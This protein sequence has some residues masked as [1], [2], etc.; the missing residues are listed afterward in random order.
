MGPDLSAA[1]GVPGNIFPLSAAQQGVWY[2]EHL[3]DEFPINVAQYVEIRGEL[4]LDTFTDACLA[5]AREMGT[6]YLR[7]T[8]IDGTPYQWVDDEMVQVVE[9]LDFT[10][11][12]NDP[13]IAALEWMRADYLKPLDLT[14]DGL[15]VMAI[16]KIGVDH[17]YWYGRMHH[18]A[19]DGYAGLTLT[20]RT[21]HRY[22]AALAGREPDVFRGLPL[23]DLNEA[24]QKYRASSRFETDAR[25]WAEQTADLPVVVN[26]SGRSGGPAPYNR[27]A[28]GELPDTVAADLALVAKQLEVSPAQVLLAA[29][30]VFLTKMTGTD[31]TMVTLPVTGRTTMALKR[32][33]GMV[34]NTV[35]IVLRCGPGVSVS[36]LIART[37][38]DITGALRHQRY[39][40]EDIRR[41]AGLADPHTGS[42]GPS[43]NMMFFDTEIKFGDSIGR[44]NI[45]TSGALDDLRINLYQSGPDAP[46]SVDFHGNPNNYD[47][48]ELTG[49][50][51][52]FLLLLERFLT[53]ATTTEVASLDVLTECERAELVAR[54]D[55]ADT[56]VELLPDLLTTFTDAAALAVTAAD[57]TM[58]YGELDERSSQLARTL[59]D[60]GVGAEDVVAV[61]IP[62]SIESVLAVWAVAKTGAAFAPIDPNYPAERIAHMVS[63]SGARTGLTVGA[64]M[65]ALPT[66]I[67][68]LPIDRTDV[69]QH[70]SAPVSD[71]DRVRRVRPEHA[72]YLIYTSGS[73]GLPKGVVVTHRGLAGLADAERVEFGVV[74]DSRVAH[75]CS[76][77]FDVSILE[78][79][80]TFTAGATL[81]VVPPPV[82][83]GAELSDLLRREHVSH[84]IITPGAL[85]TVDPAGLHELEV[86]VGAGEAISPVLVQQWGT[87]RR[88]FNGYGPT[89][90]TIL[91]TTTALTPGTPVTI[92]DAV[93]GVGA[94]VL[95]RRLKPVPVGV[96]GE[97][98]LAGPQL[99]RGY[100]ARSATT[101]DRFVASPFVAG[102]RMYRTGDVVRLRQTGEL[103]YSGRNDFQL[104]IRG[105]RVELGEIDAALVEHPQVESAVTVGNANTAGAVTLVSYIVGAAIDVDRLAD[106]LAKTLPAHMVPTTIMVLAQ[107]PLT[108]VGKIDRSALP[109]PERQARTYRAPATPLEEIVAG[110]YA[111]VL[112]HDRVGRDDHFFELGGDSLSATH[113]VSRLGAALDTRISVRELFDAPTVSAIAA[114]AGTH[115]G[116][117]APPALVARERPARIPLSSAQQRMWLVNQ[118]DP[119]SAA[120]NVPG[121]VRLTGPLD[122]AA[123]ATAFADVLGRHESLRTVF[124][125]DGGLPHQVIGSVAD[126]LVDVDLSP[127]AVDAGEIDSRIGVFAGKGFDVAAAIP[128]R[129]RLLQVDPHTH[130]LVVVL[131]HI[132]SDG[133]STGPL[134]RDVI[135]AYDT[136][137]RGV[138][139][140]GSR[141]AM[142][143]ADY[144]LWQHEVLGDPDDPESVFAHQIDYWRTAL[145]GVPELLPLATD[146]PRPS[147]ASGRGATVPFTI[148]ADLNERLKQT[149]QAHNVTVFMVV[150]AALAALLAR[151]SGTSDV[152]VGTPVAGRGAAELDDMVGM[153]VNTVALR[154]GIELGE[155]FADLL[156]RV[157]EADLEAFDNADV[158]FEHVVEVCNPAR[159]SSYSPIV[160]VAL[161]YEGYTERKAAAS[162]VEF[163]L[164]DPPSSAT[165]FDLLVTLTELGAPASTATGLRA[166]LGYATDLFD[167]DTV[168]LFAHRFLRVLDAVTADATVMVG[169]VELLCP[170]ELAAL[171]PVRGRAGAEPV[172]LSRLL[173]DATADPAAAA[174]VLGGTSLTYGELDRR[175]NSLARILVERGARPEQLVAL[176]LPRSIDLVIAVWAVAKTGAAWLPI[177]ATHPVERIAHL[178]T[179]SAATLGV[180]LSEHR[181]VLGG[182]ANWVELDDGATIA[183]LAFRSD[184][185]IGAGELQATTTPDNAA[186]VIYT[187]GSTGKPKGVTVTHRGLANFAAEQRERYGVQPD[188]RVLQ[189]ASPSFDAWVLEFLLAVGAGATMVVTPPGLLGGDDLADLLTSERITHAFLTPTV[190]SSLQPAALDFPHTLVAGGEELP[191]D[192]AGEWAIGRRLH[193]GYGPTETTIMVCIS[194]PIDSAERVT[195]GGPIRGTSAVVLDSRLRP[196]PTGAIG[197]LYIAGL[198]CA[199]GY[200]GKAALT[201]SRFVADPFGG[202]G[203]Q[204]YRTGDLVRWTKDLTLEYVGRSDFQVKVRGFRIELGEIDAA[205]RTH[206]DVAFAVTVARDTPAGDSALV[207]YVSASASSTLDSAAV[208]DH[209]RSLLPAYMVPTKVVELEEIPLNPVGKLDRTA[210]PDPGF[211]S[212]L[213]FVVPRSSD[214]HIIAG[215]FADVLGV[216]RVSVLDGFFELGG[217]SLSATQVV[218]RLGVAFGRRVEVRELFAAGTVAALAER[219]ADTPVSDVAPLVHVADRPLEIPLSF[220]QAGMWTINQADPESSSYNISFALRLTGELDVSVLR[221]ALADV[222]QRHE[223]LRTVYPLGDSGPHQV[224]LSAG[225]ALS[226]VTLDPIAVDSAALD[227]RIATCGARGFDVTIDSPIRAELY[228][229]TADDHVLSV[230]LQH[231]SADGYSMAPLSRS[232]FVAYAARLAGYA[233]QWQPLPVQYV[234]YALWQKD[235]LGHG[236]PGSALDRQVGYWREALAGAPGVLELPTD[237]PRLHARSSDGD[238]VRFTIS[239]DLQRSLNALARS[240]NSTLFMVF[241]AAFSV[242]LARL[243]GSADIV[244]G[245][246]VAGRGHAD[247]DDAVGMFVNTLVLRTRVDGGASF[248]DVVAAARAADLAAFA[249]ADVPFEMLV[250]QLNPPRSPAYSPFFQVI[251]ALQNTQR[252]ELQLPGLTV[253]Q[254]DVAAVAAQVDLQLTLN[255][256]FDDHDVP[257]QIDAE[258]VYATAL[259]DR[260][261]VEN[262]AGRFVRVLESVVDDVDVP[263][264]DIDILSSAE[265]AEMGFDTAPDPGSPTDIAALAVQQPDAIA[266]DLH[267]HRI[268]YAELNERTEALAASL[269]ATGVTGAAALTMALL[270]LVPEL[271]DDPAELASAMQS[272]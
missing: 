262:F 266:I 28:E 42:F 132:C 145:H 27:L 13:A 2:A 85:S 138:E 265:R 115:A 99:A 184:E 74:P 224:V 47:E 89:E 263:V 32:S 237:R 101:A 197:E 93:P 257:G 100:H 174:V 140:G 19:I 170:A 198:G 56:P 63:D 188:S 144:T 57:R 216:E 238:T 271:G 24:E 179:D 61:A 119:A 79:L 25:Y 148:S 247:L 208:T 50:R 149:A 240:Q 40:Y 256:Q 51:S 186:Y 191:T 38:L 139:P 157:R 225:D 210:L 55:V 123:L 83:G 95:D 196:V 54:V 111:D 194:D 108:P 232:L 18:I 45:L 102:Q 34:A 60:R 261:T 91:A 22:E 190:L 173:A 214:E 180:T 46:I 229:L 73:T 69:S 156:V 137:V 211:G 33:G 58:T 59:I 5:A 88:F 207:S 151:V 71:A 164:L 36:D 171:T 126:A 135:G 120:Y 98:Y 30:G 270:S 31:S 268:T 217:N 109:E 136:R 48:A 267:G 129:V 178:L 199:R 128:L 72:A 163:E 82:F 236:G 212:D 192:L 234:D 76:P 177:D 228:R 206:S 165:K 64:S 251:L 202:A 130:V 96:A 264:G 193:N 162:G 35:P 49:Y 104:K 12:D 258:F 253:S 52:R 231:I 183:E 260:S 254:M 1:K 87:G 181:G 117:G 68:W 221:D 226:G 185:P 189:F 133:E 215:V 242:L 105:F 8:E 213:A 176:C 103:E 195:I 255:E 209:L 204:L 218:A 4:D 65:D 37:S 269:A 175:S 84:L 227:Q 6:G 7:L 80:V 153:F 159:T 78:M 15:A 259:F 146:R 235:A 66:D 143:Y 166:E 246:P 53:V 150:H 147:E 239:T 106:A 3:T 125:A 17:Y 142:Q 29:I 16:L 161:A 20:T 167:A 62:R 43:V 113:V 122:L 107:L 77:S 11:S 26:L 152:A 114:R 245:A 230:V 116:T 10:T 70:S 23:R 118:F 155:A 154:T 39:R 252:P 201:A 21:A 219:I 169:D 233:P 160:Q 121:I 81:V 249:N 272:L 168:E 92:G 203:G 131:H 200:L 90:A 222:V 241:H 44:Y 94:V 141:L 187:S 124:P 75:V 243:S 9:R 67:H 97:L 110:V 220:A 172:V 127:Q 134:L 182:S 41:D 86:V 14:R 223:A 248:R 158:P 250:Q 112:Q 244:V 205:L